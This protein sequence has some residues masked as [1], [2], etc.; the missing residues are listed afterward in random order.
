MDRF[1]PDCLLA[2]LYEPE[3]GLMRAGQMTLQRDKTAKD[4]KIDR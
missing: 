4:G 1:G 3:F 2:E